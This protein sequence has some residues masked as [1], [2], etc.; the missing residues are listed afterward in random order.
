MNIRACRE[1][2]LAEVE[3]EVRFTARALGFDQLTPAVRAALAEVP[4][5]SF[6]PPE[7]RELA[8]LDYPLPMAA[9]SPFPSPTSLPS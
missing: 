3:A 7:Q 4:R 8:Y 9:P 6:V 1:T 2:L 5:H